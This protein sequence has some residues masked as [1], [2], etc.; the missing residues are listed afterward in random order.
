[1]NTPSP[2]SARPRGGWT[3]I[4]LLVVIAVIGILVG[5][6]MPAVQQAREAARRTQCRNNIKQLALAMQTYVS[7]HGTFP[8]SYA[9]GPYP[10]GL[11]DRGTSWMTMILPQIDQVPLYN[12][13]EF[14][15]PFA[16]LNNVLAA[17]ESVPAFH[18]P[19]DTHSG[20]MDFRSNIQGEWG[21]NNYKACAGSNWSFG[22]YGPVVS[23]RGRN[24]GNPN[25]LDFGNGLICR[26]GPGPIVTRPADV[27]DGASQTFAI[28]EAVPEWCRHT[29]WF[30]FNATTATCGLPPNHFMKPDLQ[31]A[32]EGN[33][34]ENYSF[35][36]RHPG[37]VHFAMVDGSVRFI[38]D[39]INVFVYWDLAT[40]SG[41]EPVGDF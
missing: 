14:G 13:I 8:I 30:W 19:S 1:M 34:W 3:L 37:G 35:N 4:E 38:S 40:I 17:R 18:C 7:T 29:W 22:P 26:G 11:E 2:A 12:R 23:L 16:A 27:R 9:T 10:Y 25:G 6:I 33:W 24:A 15:K 21:V 28:G 31:V 20:R 39:S 36:S 41:G 5:L 32:G